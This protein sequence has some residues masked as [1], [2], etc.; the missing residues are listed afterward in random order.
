MR[1]LN[2]EVPSDPLNGS[3]D[4]RELPRYPESIES[5]T[6]LQASRSPRYHGN[7]QLASL[8][9]ETVIDLQGFYCLSP[10]NRQ[11]GP[12]IRKS[13]QGAREMEIGAYGF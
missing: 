9:W 1:S 5:I 10:N 6:Q 12:H 11:P 4:S 2:S 7:W 3:R 13:V 8:Q